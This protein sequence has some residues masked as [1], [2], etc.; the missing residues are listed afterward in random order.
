MTADTIAKVCAA[1]ADGYL[2]KPY[3][4]EMLRAKLATAFRARELD[5]LSPQAVR[6]AS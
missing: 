1:G 2:L 5:R 3:D 4:A 6:R